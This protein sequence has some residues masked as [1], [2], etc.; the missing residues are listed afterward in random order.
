MKP[1]TVWKATPVIITRKTYCILNMHK[2]NTYAG[3]RFCLDNGD[4]PLYAI[5]PNARIPVVNLRGIA[6]ATR[7]R[8]R[9]QKTA[10]KFKGF[11]EEK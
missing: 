11:R 2:R 7:N 1:V 8:L 6:Y 10:A 3:Y 4:V 5:T 9:Y